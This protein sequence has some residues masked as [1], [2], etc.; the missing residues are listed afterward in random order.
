MEKYF[1]ILWHT[2]GVIE[3]TL[4]GDSYPNYSFIVQHCK[5]I[6]ISE[7]DIV[8]YEVHY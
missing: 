7:D 3:F 6:D 8:E 1:I 5:A 4:I 2:K